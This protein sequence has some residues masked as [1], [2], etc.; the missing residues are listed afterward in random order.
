MIAWTVVWILITVSMFRG[1]S[2]YDRATAR[3]EKTK[4]DITRLQEENAKLADQI[5]YERTPLA[6]E[7]RV[8]DELQLAKPG[9]VLVEFVTPTLPPSQSSPSTD[10]SSNSTGSLDN[11]ANNP[12]VLG[13]LIPSLQK[14]PVFEL[15]QAFWQN[16]VAHFSLE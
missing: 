6:Q 5:S 15:L 3:L 1:L 11:S 12:Q 14:N 16:I 8:R 2:V 7:K 4:Q 10:S 13:V 9:E